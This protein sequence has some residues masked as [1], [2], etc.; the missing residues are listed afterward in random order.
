MTEVTTIDARSAHADMHLVCARALFRATW[1]PSLCSP[2]PC[3][4]QLLTPVGQHRRYSKCDTPY[5]TPVIKFGTENAS[6]SSQPCFTLETSLHLRAPLHRVWAAF[7]VPSTLNAITP[8]HLNFTVTTP[9]P[10]G[11]REGTI[12]DYRF[13]LH[14]STASSTACPPIAPLTHPLRPQ[15]SPPRRALQMAHTARRHCSCSHIPRLIS[16]H[17]ISRWDPPHGFQDEQVRVRGVA[18]AG[19]GQQNCFLVLTALQ[20]LGPYSLWQHHHAYTATCDERGDGTLCSDIV[21]CHPCLSAA[22]SMHVFPSLGNVCAG[23]GCRCS[24][25]A[26]WRI[27]G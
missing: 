23:T 16:R 9:Q 12:I 21:R 2:L 11:M 22:S 25:W 27:S 5:E 18:R 7:H 4:P 8:P 6:S 20:E 1:C 3:R 13:S 14:F 17:R 15:P 24:R 10:V 19:L 26:T